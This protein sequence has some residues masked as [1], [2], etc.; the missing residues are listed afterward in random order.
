MCAHATCMHT[1]TYVFTRILLSRNPNSLVFVFSF[2][3]FIRFT[4][5]LT[6]CGLPLGPCLSV[7]CCFVVVLLLLCLLGF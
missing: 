5:C 3:L 1:H 7:L 6:C 4:L 2:V